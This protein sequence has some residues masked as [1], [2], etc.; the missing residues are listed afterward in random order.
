MIGVW[1]PSW[2]RN[3]MVMVSGR[4]GRYVPDGISARGRVSYRHQPTPLPW[5]RRDYVPDYDVIPVLN[6]VCDVIMSWR[7]YVVMYRKWE[8]PS[9]IQFSFGEITHY[10]IVVTSINMAKS[11]IFRYLN[12][13]VLTNC[14]VHIGH[15]IIQ[16][17]EQDIAS[18][19][20]T[21]TL[22]KIRILF[23]FSPLIEIKNLK[24]WRNRSP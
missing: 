18:C 5:Q 23:Y 24:I 11:G 19:Y 13:V 10:I 12:D 15:P 22:G 21:N 9:D 20:L 14:F 17:M 1:K 4:C 2:W 7:H 16:E 6:I 3:E 8:T